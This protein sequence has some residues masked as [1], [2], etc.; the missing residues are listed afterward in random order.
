MEFTRFKDKFD[1]GISVHTMA[2][3]NELCSRLKE[4]EAQIKDL[5]T[6]LQV[7]IEY[8]SLMS[9]R[10]VRA[11]D[12]DKTL[13][14]LDT[15]HQTRALRCMAGTRLD[16]I[17]FILE[18]VRNIET[19]LNILWI[20]GYPGAGKSTLAMHIAMIFRVAHRLGV[21]V[22]FN[23]NTGVTA[24]TLWK[25]IA[26]ALAREYRECRNVIV[27]KIKSGSLDLANTTSREI[28]N[29]LIAEPLRQ[30]TASHTKMSQY[31]LPAIIIDALDEAGGLD[32]SSRKARK[33]VLDCLTDWSNL[34]PGVKLI[35]T[36]RV[37]QD[38]ELAFSK[39]PHK[40]LEIPTGS[41]VTDTSNSTRDIQLYLR[42]E[43]KNIAYGNKIEGDWPGNEIIA[44]LACRAQGV[45]IWATTVLSFVDGVD[46]RY[47]LKT[48]LDGQLPAG[49]VYGLYRQILN[50]SF[51]CT[52][53]PNNFVLIVSAVV[54]LQQPFT[55][56]ELAH[57]LCLGIDTV[58]GVCKGL[59][60]LLDDGDVVRFKHQSFVDFLTSDVGQPALSPSDEATACPTRFH[61]NISDA[62]GHLYRSMF[63]LMHKELHFNI[64]NM[65]SSFMRND[66]L[67][68]NHFESAIS[69]PLAYACRFWSFHLSNTQS[70]LELDLIKTFVLEDLL[71]W[72][73][74]LSGLK[75]LTVAAPSL[76]SLRERLSSS[77]EQVG[78]HTFD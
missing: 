29:Q 56:M 71:S 18:W 8:S 17:S 49:N 21:I 77:P 48:I 39:V 51:P 52:Y 25:S 35:V 40:K 12:D 16:L 1:R 60:T 66:E 61:I 26:Y 75:S 19:A 69:H 63:R 5:G 44:D 47:Q 28:F 13:E 20:Y 34:A 10:L 68:K 4:L 58:N 64:C 59:R 76:L 43:F 55:P 72:F 2:T 11:D 53:D 67:P 74:C 32:G 33:E 78:I 65:P 62:H 15:R 9:L 31:R 36:S 45:F 6:Y 50:T 42:N 22:E 57:L 24:V 23:R 46:P 41:L 30:L 27:T 14:V 37:E 7:V 3:T 38:I 54:V 70:E 73:E